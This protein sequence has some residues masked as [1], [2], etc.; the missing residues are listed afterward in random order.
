MNAA[1]ERLVIRT[2]H[3]LLSIPLAG[4]LYGPLPHIPPAV[5]VTRFVAFPVVVISGFWLWLKPRMV[6]WWWR[7]TPSRGRLAAE[8][9]QQQSG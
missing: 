6:R 5:F 9:D 1:R 3:L 7:R 4:Y 8:R 2:L